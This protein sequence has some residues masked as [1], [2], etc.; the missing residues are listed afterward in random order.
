MKEDSLAAHFR[1]QEICRFSEDAAS[2]SSL[3]SSCPP[4]IV[5]D[6]DCFERDQPFDTPPIATC[7]ET[8]QL[9]S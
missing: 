7:Q 8:N 6:A 4:C 3:K 1:S 2:L 5:G 9:V